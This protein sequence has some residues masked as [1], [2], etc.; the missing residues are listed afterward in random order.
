MHTDTQSVQEVHAFS[1]PGSGFQ[2]RR[3]PVRSE[4]GEGQTHPRALADPTNKNK[5]SHDRSGVPG[6]ETNVP[7]RDSE[8]RIPE[9]LEKVIPIPKSLHSHLKW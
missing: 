4:G 8:A 5:R 9:S 3:L 2:L 1:H 7:D 6:L